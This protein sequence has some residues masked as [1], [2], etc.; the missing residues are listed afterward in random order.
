MNNIKLDNEVINY[1]VFFK[2]NKNMYLRI[3]KNFLVITAPK[4][5]KME[6]IELFILRNKSFILKHLQ[7]K[8]K[9]LYDNENFLLW[10]EKIEISEE[11]IDQGKVE[12]YYQQ[13]TIELAKILIK[14][15]FKDFVKEVNLDGIIIKSRL[16]KTRLGS[17]NSLTRT[18]NLNSLLARFDQKFLRAVLLHELVHLNVP[19]HQKGFYNLLLQYEPNYKNIKKELNKLIKEYQI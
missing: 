13:Q 10:G 15:E 4:S 12:K 5:V 9:T 18:I 3:K 16:M 14:S 2:K 19:N 11:M 1:Q 17:C 6:Q 8:T 7:T